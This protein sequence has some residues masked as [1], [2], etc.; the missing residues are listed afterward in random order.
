MR[1]PDLAP[2]IARQVV[3]MVQLLRGLD[4]KKSPSVA[5]TVDWAKALVAINADVLDERII[6]D[7]LSVVLKHESDV[8]K[9][10]KNL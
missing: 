8:R 6:K 4:L 2:A 1:A 7:T 10:K 3:E 9:A 5:E